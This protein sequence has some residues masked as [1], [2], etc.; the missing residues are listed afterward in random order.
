MLKKKSDKN[1]I[2]AVDIRVRDA[3]R[4]ERKAARIRVQDARRAEREATEKRVQDALRAQRIV[5]AVDLVDMMS[6][7]SVLRIVN[8][9]T[10]EEYDEAVRRNEEN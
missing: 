8:G 3:R 7:E 9:L 2:P 4:A 10:D 5:H 1:C 6:R